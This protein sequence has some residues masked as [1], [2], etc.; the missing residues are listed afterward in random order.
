MRRLNVRRAILALVLIAIAGYG[1]HRLCVIPYR[2]NLV[3]REVEER[4]SVVDNVDSFRAMSLAR[5]NLADLDRI[6]HTRRNDPAWYMFYGANLEVLDRWQDAATVY[7]NALAIDQRPEI[8][9]SRGLAMLHLGKIE[10]AEADMITAVRFNEFFLYQI[11]GE[12]RTRVA[13][14]A[15]RS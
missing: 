15:G 6:E 11:D 9:Y 4:M 12:L 14:G 5:L 3:M 8:Y 7:T 2:A 13:A 1:I 10:Q